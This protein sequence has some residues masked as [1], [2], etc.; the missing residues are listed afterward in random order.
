MNIPKTPKQGF[1]SHGRSNCSLW[2]AA[3]VFLSELL[4]LEQ[5]GILAEYNS[6]EIKELEGNVLV[7]PV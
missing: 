2:L 6:G 7:A 4:Q 1:L 5:F 3:H